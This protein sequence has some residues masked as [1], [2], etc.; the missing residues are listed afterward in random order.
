LGRRYAPFVLVVAVQALLVAIVP[1]KAPSQSQVAASAGTARSGG[2]SQS[3]ADR[4]GDAN[5]TSAASPDAG[6]VPAGATDTATG[7]AGGGTSA[8]GTT[9]SRGAA[10]PARGAAAG[11]AGPVD[12]SHCDAN[13]FEIGPSFYMPNCEPVW[14]GGDNGGSTMTG[15][16]ATEIRYLFY[17]TKSDPQVTA[18]L[19]TQGLAASKHDQCAAWA[20]FDKAINKRWEFYGRKAVSLDGPGNHKGSTVSGCD[21]HY[22]HYQGQCALTPPD[23]PCLRAEAAQMAAMKPAFVLV[24]VSPHPALHNELGKRH[25]MVLGGQ[26]QPARYHV[27]VAPYHYDP[28]RDGELASRMMAEYWCKKLAGK[29]VRYAG[30]DVM[31]VNPPIRKVGISFP[32]TD[33]DPTYKIGVDIFAHLI[34]GGLCGSSKD[35]PLLRPY[36]SDITTAQQQSQTSSTAYKRAGV[37]TVICFCDPIAPVFQTA[38]M[39]QQ[40]YHPEHLIAGVG[41][42]D[43]DVLGRLYSPTQWNHAFG[44]SELQ[45]FATYD[46]TDQSK[47]WRDV[48]NAGTPDTT[49]GLPWAYYNLFASAVQLAGP[50]ITPA[51]IKTGLFSARGLGGDPGH[52]YIKFG[53]RADDYTGIEDV[54]EV[55]WSATARS[56]VDG[57]P[58]AYVPVDG[59]RRYKSGQIPG[60]DPKVFQ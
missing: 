26:W 42:I 13:G 43:Y 39:D 7:V 35:A 8:S 31:G 41:L 4:A 30:P 23:P 21:A 32:A 18:V 38:A 12:R 15:V 53:A 17:A 6:G 14:H 46:Q 9:G 5:A 56:N 1:S 34:T 44:L 33:G 58:G 29:P 47:A 45:N 25:I 10:G 27:D 40:G 60:G 54:R 37:T 51:T 59:G 3:V 20:A 55:W 11:P 2:T 49:E 16:S 28:F 36:N 19:A 50:N 52:P 22:P 24:P 57:K 48:G